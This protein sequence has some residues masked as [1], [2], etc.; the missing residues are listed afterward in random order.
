MNLNFEI[1]LKSSTTSSSWGELQILL[2]IK[3]GKSQQLITTSQVC[4]FLTTWSVLC[5]T[6]C[7]YKY[8]SFLNN[9][10]HTYNL[11]NTPLYLNFSSRCFLLEVFQS[12]FQFRQ[13]FCFSL[14]RVGKILVQIASP[15]KFKMADTHVKLWELYLNFQQI[16]C[17]ICPQIAKMQ[18]KHIAVQCIVPSYHCI[19]S[20]YSFI[21]FFHSILSFYILSCY[22]FMLFFHSIL[23]FYSFML[24]FHSILSC[25]SFILFFIYKERIEWKNRMKEWTK[26]GFEP[27]ITPYFF[28]IPN[29]LNFAF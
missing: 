28:T 10:V 9:F 24:F 15:V 8:N 14:A 21:I 26:K 22:S 17:I 20:F 1:V 2:A 16:M 6:M 13:P 27:N 5:T 11:N 25:Y 7:K 19:L 29:D 23:S 12:V 3:Y 18:P 4:V